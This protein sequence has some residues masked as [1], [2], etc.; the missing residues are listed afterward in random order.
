VSLKVLMLDLGGTLVNDGTVLPHAKEALQTFAEM[1]TVDGESLEMCLVSDFKMPAPP[2]T[3]SKIR[4]IFG[5]YLELLEQFG[6]REYFLPADRRIT[7]STHAGVNKPNRGIFEKAIE[8]LSVNAV[9][10]ECLF[11]TEEPA[12][13]TACAALGMGTLRFGS[14]EGFTD[15]ADAPLLVAAKLAAPRAPNMANALGMWLRAK[16]GM[17]VVNVNV[18]PRGDRATARVKA[19]WAL[20]AGELG[21]QQLHVEMP[22]VMDLQL[23]AAG[24][25]RSMAPT[26]PS[27]EEISEA[28]DFVKTLQTHGQIANENERT[29]ALTTHQLVQDAQGRTVL[30][31]QRFSA[32]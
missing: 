19:A 18:A 21:G 5:E 32:L 14:V 2:T 29:P 26:A 16:H 20:P 13:L 4:E 1:E 9:L 22:A 8:R 7:L 24:H 23:D 3:S 15:W 11:I 17:Q 12:H 27:D 25:V 31:R 28:V 10:K 6:V 30:R